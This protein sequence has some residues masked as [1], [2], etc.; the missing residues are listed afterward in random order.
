MS[1]PHAV[2]GASVQTPASVAHRAGSFVVLG[3]T[4]IL[5]IG[6]LPRPATATS[7]SLYDSYQWGLAAGD[8]GQ[9]S[10]IQGTNPAAILS[11]TQPLITKTVGDT[12]GD[13][14]TLSLQGAATPGQLHAFGSM[15]TT[16][17]GTA[18]PLDAASA[19][20]ELSFAWFDTLTFNSATLAA[21]TPI[22]Y[23]LEYVL[24]STMS[25]TGSP[26]SYLS[27]CATA[28][29]GSVLPSI[30]MT[31]VG[32]TTEL[33][34]SPCSAAGPGSDHMVAMPTFAAHVGD[35]VLIQEGLAIAGSAGSGGGNPD[36]SENVTLNAAD[37]GSLYVLI[38]TPGVT[39]NA[40]SGA[41]YQAPPLNAAV[42]EPASMLLL[43][44]GLIGMG[45][46]RWRNR[47]HRG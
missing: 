5:A 7:F 2:V 35:S 13:T 37:T 31:G 46:R 21:G 29:A 16:W 15:A 36:L 25:E 20:V 1:R 6:A 33:I 12:I 11:L 41:T 3:L 9:S 26:D 14:S 18:P 44:T 47:R 38:N 22:S 23:T 30:V 19:V 45:A 27:L 8:A 17:N 10:G 39:F 24:D 42:P 40:A 28:P 4:F 32:N 43:G 34:R